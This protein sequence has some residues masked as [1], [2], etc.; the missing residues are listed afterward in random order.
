MLWTGSR[1]RGSDWLSDQFPVPVTHQYRAP[2]GRSC[3]D[4]DGTGV[5]L[6]HPSACLHGPPYNA[7]F[8]PKRSLIPGSAFKPMD[9]LIS[10]PGRPC[11]FDRGGSFAARLGKTKRAAR[12]R[13]FPL[14]VWDV[15]RFSL[16]CFLV[17][18]SAVSGRPCRVPL[19]LGGGGDVPTEM[20]K[21][22]A[23]LPRTD[24][25]P[26]SSHRPRFMR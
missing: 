11:R 16:T 15:F 6:R 20:R 17:A 3:S 2:I 4:D 8:E 10:P 21:R 5:R 14:F 12:V 9:G 7:T 18:K 1:L 23:D 13:P 26:S 22:A 19:L 25:L 24:T